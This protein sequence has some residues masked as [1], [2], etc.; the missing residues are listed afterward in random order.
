[1][2]LDPVAEEQ[3]SA[4]E[5][6]DADTECEDADIDWDERRKQL[7]ENLAEWLGEHF[8]P[9][10]KEVCLGLEKMFE[11]VQKYKTASALVSAFWT[12]GKGDKNVF[13]Y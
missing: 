7:C 2:D 13:V 10:K 9:S 5:C 4:T 3:T 12:F 11:E 8:I 1:M 6:E